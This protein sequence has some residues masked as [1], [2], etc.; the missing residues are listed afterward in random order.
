MYWNLLDRLRK[1]LRAM[2]RGQPR[3]QLKRVD[4]KLG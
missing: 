4:L 1:H 3:A 2:A